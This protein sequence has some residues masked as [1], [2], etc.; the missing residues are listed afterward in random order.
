[1]TD[2]ANRP[3]SQF[4]PVSEADLPAE[5]RAAERT[6]A[7][8]GAGVSTA[9]GIPSFRGEDGLWNEWDPNSVHRRRLDA[10]PKG[11]WRDRLELRESLYEGSDPEPNA[12]HRALASMEADGHLDGV[13]TQNVD[14]LHAA[15]GSERLVELHG[16]NRRVR[17]DDCGEQRSA[18]PVFERAADGELPPRC[19]CGGL[20][21]P[22]VVL[23]GESLPDSAMERA[24]R[25]ARESDVMLAVGSSLSVRPASLLPRIAV[26]AGATLAVVN[27]EETPLDSDAEYLFRSDVTDLLP[28]VA[29]R[30]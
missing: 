29:D 20:Y 12:A 27:F 13:V 18:T 1:M 11:F 3:R 5:I 2:R 17:C 15:A 28:A 4:R 24:Q 7:L 10:D 19:G 23:F 21:R 22:D 25:L 16:T 14:G 8:T 6:V 9:S 30:L 26:Q